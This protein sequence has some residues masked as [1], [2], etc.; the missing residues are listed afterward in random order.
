MPAEV[1]YLVVAMTNLVL[2]LSLR[3]Q[4]QQLSAHQG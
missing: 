4:Q 2:G 1:T 3:L